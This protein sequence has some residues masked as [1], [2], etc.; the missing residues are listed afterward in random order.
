M[1]RDEAINYVTNE[2]KSIRGSIIKGDSVP[3]LKFL[4]LSEIFKFKIE[5]SSDRF[6][7]IVLDEASKTENDKMHLKMIDDILRD[8]IEDS[9]ESDDV[10]TEEEVT[11]LVDFDGSIRSSKVPD[12]IA[13]NTSIGAKKTTDQT[14]ASTRQHGVWIGSGNFFKRYYGE[15]VE[16]ADLS[17]TL[18]YDETKDSG[19]EETKDYFEDSL[20]MDEK[21]AEDRA[22]TFGKTEHLDDRGD[23]YQRLTEKDTL[24]K[25]AE[26]RAKEMIEVIL[27]KR[28]ESDELSDGKNSLLD[29][30]LKQ[31]HKLSK[32]N[33]LSTDDLVEKLKSL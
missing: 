23:G 12:G 31:L 33:G 1:E 26:D 28:D 19:W 21:E 30:K 18:G 6:T 27:S 5:P 20:D 8:A 14:V 22:E 16:E 17:K 15:S 10:G 9:E 25:I 32:A 7:A 2:L 29:G 13:N 4:Q 24:K 11:E 3:T